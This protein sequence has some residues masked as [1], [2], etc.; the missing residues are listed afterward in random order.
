MS[1][2]TLATFNFPWPATPLGR[3]CACAAGIS[4]STLAILGFAGLPR[5][6]GMAAPLLVH[7][8][9]GLFLAAPPA[10]ALLPEGVPALLF[11]A[12]FLAALAASSSI[13]SSRV[14]SIGSSS[15]NDKCFC[16]CTAPR[17]PTV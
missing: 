16:G 2:F 11:L 9:S 13:A 17:V 8:G 14:T 4:S 12:V 10:E 3:S 1:N 7:P 6:F 5:F 15:C